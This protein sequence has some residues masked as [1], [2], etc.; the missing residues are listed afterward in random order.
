MKYKILLADQESASAKKMIKTL[1]N[2]GNFVFFTSFYSEAI[3]TLES[4]KF[5]ILIIDPLISNESGVDLIN[6]AREIHEYIVVFVLATPDN[7]ANILTTL[8]PFIY[9][10]V[11]KPYDP[12][13]IVQNISRIMSKKR[14]RQ[15]YNI[16][17]IGA[18]PG[19]V[20][21]GCGGTLSMHAFKGDNI[22]IAILDAKSD[23]SALEDAKTSAK[24]L[25]AKLILGDETEYPGMSYSH[26][27]LKFIEDVIYEY[28]P[29]V[30]YTHCTAEGL[31]KRKNINMATTLAAQ[32][33]PIVYGYLG[34]S[35]TIEFSPNHFGDISS[36]VKGKQKLLD[37]Y[38]SKKTVPYFSRS[39]T[40]G[41]A[42]YWGHF[43]GFTL[44][45]PFEILKR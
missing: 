27:S 24:L 9:G 15:K 39:M 41:T 18:Y 10:Y 12:D 25:G 34:Q 36:H 40:E 19:D 16:L 31:R 1:E 37:S 30:I 7:C 6:R 17:A 38:K 13:K 29:G 32:Q 5:D 21:I 23:P 44:V 20:E 22:T 28:K 3:H 14:R 4:N 33:A 35:S 11:Y 2:L 26:Y 43:V 8:Q 42:R 45:E